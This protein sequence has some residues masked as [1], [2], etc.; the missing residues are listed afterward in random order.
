MS[1]SLEVVIIGDENADRIKPLLKTFASDIRFDIKIWSPVYLDSFNSEKLIA[2]GFEVDK[3]TVYML[4]KLSL[5]EI[6]CVLAH[7][8]ARS[9]LATKEFGGVILE[10]DARI[11]NV[12]Y[13]FNS[14]NIFL[15]SIKVPS[16]LNFAT[17]KKLSDLDSDC[18]R[19][20]VLQ[21]S[22]TYS[23]LAVGYV[24]NKSGAEMLANTKYRLCS[25]NDW[26][27]S[28]INKYILRA[29]AVAHGD[30]DSLSTIDPENLRGLGV[31]NW[32]KNWR[33]RILLFSFYHFFVNRNSFTS[34]LEY[35]KVMLTPR[36]LYQLKKVSPRNKI[37]FSIWR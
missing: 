23:P 21:K 12:D 15:E 16:V 8:E 28:R 10:D 32:K 1:N 24:L 33:N 22:Y 25:M 9:Y 2:S 17:S 5:R 37:L 13:F 20:P 36:I 35:V 4:T 26:P 6:G 11:P 27:Y 31:K 19:N 7:T 18:L 3:S 29:P 34:I 30:S 14:A